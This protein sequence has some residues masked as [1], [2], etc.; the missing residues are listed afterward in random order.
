MEKNMTVVRTKQE[1]AQAVQNNQSQ[2]VIE[3]DIVNGI[4][5]LKLVGPLAWTIAAASIATAAYLFAAA[6]AATVASAPVGGAGGAISFTGAIGTAAAAVAILGI[7]ATTVAIGI[8]VV[9]G[10]IG[11][12]TKLREKY[13]IIEKSKDR[14]VLQRKG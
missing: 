6:P 3:G 4:V 8:A 2:I 9:A 1:L 14:V 12:L 11:A 5:R 7:P 13:K 10:G